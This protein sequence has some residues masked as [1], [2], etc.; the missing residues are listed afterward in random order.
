MPNWLEEDKTLDELGAR[1]ELLGFVLED[2]LVSPYSGGGGIS[3]FEVQ[4]K[5]NDKASVK[6]TVNVG[7]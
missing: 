4:E 1:D 5:M 6:P 2:E 7:A 3:M